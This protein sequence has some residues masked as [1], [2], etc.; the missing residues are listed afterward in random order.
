MIVPT[1]EIL[2]SPGVFRTLQSIDSR[3]DFYAARDI[4]DLLE[5]YGSLGA[6]LEFSRLANSGFVLDAPATGRY[7]LTTSGKKLLLLSEAANG[8]DLSDVIQELTILF[9]AVRP[10]ELI[11]R[12]IG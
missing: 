4:R 12:D 6:D 5:T 10:Y 1:I 8:R 2:G 9:P 11:L 7:S 3:P